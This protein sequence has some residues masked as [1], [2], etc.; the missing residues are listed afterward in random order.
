[1]AETEGKILTCDLCG[2]TVFLKYIETKDYDGGFTHVRRYEDRPYGW[3]T[4]H[5][6]D[7]IHSTLCPSCNKKMN[8]AV[9]RCISEI[10]RETNQ[11][12]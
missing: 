3:Q 4:W 12:D 2:E 9:L 5:V 7:I 8:E 11:D 10:Q 6:T 1:M